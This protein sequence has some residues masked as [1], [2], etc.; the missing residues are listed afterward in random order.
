MSRI[1]RTLGAI[2]KSTLENRHE[3]HHRVPRFIEYPYFARRRFH[4]KVS[5]P[6]A[7]ICES[8][9]F[10]GLISEESSYGLQEE[11]TR[12]LRSIYRGRFKAG[13]HQIVPRCHHFHRSWIAQYF[14]YDTAERRA[15][16]CRHASI[17]HTALRAKRKRRQRTLLHH[18]H[19]AIHTVLQS[20]RAIVGQT[21]YN[22]TSCC[23]A[24]II[25]IIANYWL[26]LPRYYWWHIIS[27]YCI[28]LIADIIISLFSA[29]LISFC[30]ISIWFH[31]I[32]YIFRRALPHTRHIYIRK[33]FRYAY[34][35]L[36]ITMHIVRALA[37]KTRNVS[38]QQ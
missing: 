35:L 19:N 5:C 20:S 6:E 34:I 27:R 8:K 28:W 36:I 32:S 17:T 38:F 10:R 22:V 29:R 9:K 7:T 12:D 31:F 23:L 3:Y 4:N 30:Y 1:W 14:I 24:L 21:Q 11:A 26:I 33:V 37:M 13:L 18:S 25:I 16:C 2:P 15:A